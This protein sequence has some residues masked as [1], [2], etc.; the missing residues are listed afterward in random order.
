MATRRTKRTTKRVKNLAAKK[1]GAKRA[2]E[3]KGGGKVSFQELSVSHTMD[4]STPKSF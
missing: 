3:V 1:V 4:K 2:K